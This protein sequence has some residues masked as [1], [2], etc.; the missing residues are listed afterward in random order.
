[1]TKVV[2][3]PGSARTR[4]LRLLAENHSNTELVT[5]CRL[6]LVFIVSSIMIAG[7]S[8]SVVPEDFQDGSL[9][10]VINLTQQPY[11]FNHEM[12]MKER[13]YNLEYYQRPQ[14]NW[15]V[16]RR[17]GL[18]VSEFF[19]TYDAKWP[20]I[21]TDVVS[22]WPAINWTKEVFIQKYG[23]ER[24]VMKA[25][26]GGL[27]HA[28]GHAL[29]LEVFID[30]LNEASF[31]TWTYLEDELFLVMR[32]ELRKDIGQNMVR[33]WD[34]MM[35]WGTAH[36]RST[37]HMDPYNWT[38]ISA[39]LQGHKK[40]KLIPPGQ[41]HL[42]Y[43]DPEARCGFPLE[44]R[45]Y[46]SPIDAFDVDTKK[47]PRFKRL[48]VLEADVYSGEMLIIPT[49]WY[50]QA[51]NVE[52]TL[53]LSQQM[54]NRNN[55]LAILEEIIKA[56]NLKR[57][58]LPTYF[59]TLLPPDQVKVLMSLLPKKVLQHGHDVTKDILEQIKK[60]KD[61]QN[62]VKSGLEDGQENMSIWV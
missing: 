58:K 22:K 54:M 29:P 39:V 16:E 45:K 21:L 20:V 23:K 61:N 44:C 13:E 46:N 17:S 1:M 9:E 42:L 19:D 57:K 18:S 2:A 62:K 56:G 12:A 36:S 15:K 25:V 38:G 49:G 27:Q 41:D 28:T 11:T 26:V 5:P 37:L 48:Q 3:R 55:Y 52:Q 34:C 7:I 51:F 6:L 43:V 47:Y 40:W 14:H 31:D 33:P 30:H 4:A 60:T 10:E 35:L 50:H 8:F 59:S 24:V 32:P 53:A